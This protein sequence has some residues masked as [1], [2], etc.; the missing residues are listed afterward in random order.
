MKV[1]ATKGAPGG[2]EREQVG[3][4]YTCFQASLLLPPQI[5]VLP[6]HAMCINTLQY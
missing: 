4:A 6:H 2:G 5:Y 3:A 1:P